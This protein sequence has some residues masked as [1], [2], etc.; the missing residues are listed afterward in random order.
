MNAVKFQKSEIN[1]Y[2]YYDHCRFKINIAPTIIMN[3]T[4]FFNLSLLL[5]LVPIYFCSIHFH[6]LNIIFLVFFSVSS[7]FLPSFSPSSFILQLNS[8]AVIDWFALWTRAIWLKYKTQQQ[9]LTTTRKGNI[10]NFINR[11]V[12]LYYSH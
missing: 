10:L 9:Q 8:P 5:L 7:L 12:Y 2:Y 4:I 11:W 6:L 1:Y 3:S